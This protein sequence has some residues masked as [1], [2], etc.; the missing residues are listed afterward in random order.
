MQVDNSLEKT[1][2]SMELLEFLTVYSGCRFI[3]DLKSTT[4]WKVVLK[5]ISEQD[6]LVNQFSLNEWKQALKYLK[7]E[8]NPG[9]SR[10]AILQQLLKE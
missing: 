1:G 3:S 6:T 2:N 10:E 8:G 9:Q 7:N 5:K 4:Q